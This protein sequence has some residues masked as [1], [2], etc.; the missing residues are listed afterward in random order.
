MDISLPERQLAIRRAAAGL[1][2]MF[3]WA[4][5]H[6]VPLPN[7]RRADLLA[8]RP[9]GGFVCI[10]VKSGIRDFLTDD[11][12]PDYREFC[13][14]LYFAVDDSFPTD[15]IPDS[16]GLIVAAGREAAMVRQ[17][18]AHAL[19]PARRRAL[20][21]RFASLAATR[22]AALEHPSVTASLRAALRSE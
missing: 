17:A 8:L 9:D 6:E 21:H 19:P 22:L 2:Q 1:C 16:A 4:P 12:W 11:K 5:L 14:A 3:A 18:P 20:T 15:M 7:G 13:D 10:E